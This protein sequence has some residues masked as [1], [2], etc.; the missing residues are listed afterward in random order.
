MNLIGFLKNIA[1]ELSRKNMLIEEKINDI[2]KAKLECGCFGYDCCTG[3]TQLAS[4]N[5]SINKG[6]YFADNGDLYFGTHEQAK[7]VRAGKPNTGTKI[8]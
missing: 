7:A 4:H 5:K 6:F 8:N 2:F 1:Y 3:F